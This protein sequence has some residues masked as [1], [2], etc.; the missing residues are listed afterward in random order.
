VEALE[1]L[2]RDGPRLDVAELAEQRHELLERER[3]VLV[4]VHR[5][6]PSNDVAH[7]DLVY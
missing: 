7:K 2:G 1:V 5:V 4:K 3:A 6:E